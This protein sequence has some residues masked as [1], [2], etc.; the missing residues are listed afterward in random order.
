LAGSWL[1][2]ELKIGVPGEFRECEWLVA[3]LSLT[4]SH[5]HRPVTFG[6]GPE[7]LTLAF[8]R[9]RSR[10]I[11]FGD[12]GTLVRR[13]QWEGPLDHLDERSARRERELVGNL[14]LYLQGHGLYQKV[15]HFCE[16]GGS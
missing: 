7:L 6:G 15:F 11:L 1:G 3:L 10:L 4:R 9:A 14:V 13:R 2:K 5:A 12:P 16:V 8:T